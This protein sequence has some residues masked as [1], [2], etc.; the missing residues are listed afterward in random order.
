MP[1]IPLTLT[2]SLCL[3]FTFVLFFLSEHARGRFSGAERDSLLPL[4]EETRRPQTRPAP[5]AAVTVEHDH[6]HDEPEHKGSAHACRGGCRCGEGCARRRNS[7][8]T[9]AS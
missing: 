7:S 3:V 2:I 4:S 6:P 1:V 8:S 5:S 9:V